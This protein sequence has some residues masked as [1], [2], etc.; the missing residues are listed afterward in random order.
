MMNRRKFIKSTSTIVAGAGILATSATACSGGG[1]L[2]IALIGA[3]NQGKVLLKDCLKISGIR[4]RAICDI[5]SFNQTYAKNTLKK[6]DQEVNVY[7]DYKEMLSTEKDLD[8]VIIATPDFVH[9]EHLFACLDAGLHVYCEKEMSHT[10]QEAARMVS[11][12]EKSNKL[13]Q[14]GHQRRS[15]P[16]YQMARESIHAGELCGQLTNCYGQWNRPVQEL[17]TWPEKYVIEPETLEKYGFDSMSHFR[18]WRWFKKYSGG[19]M[20]DLGSHQVDIFSWFINS[21]PSHLQATGGRD[22]YS[23]RDWDGDVMTIYNYYLNKENNKSVRAFYQV[24]NTNGFGSYYERFYGDSGSL[25]ISENGDQCYYVPE[26]GQPVPSWIE[27][28]EPVNMNGV[29]AY[30]L[31]AAFQNQSEESKERILPFIDKSI[32]QLHLEN[33]FNSII[34]NKKSNLNCSPSEAYRTAVAVLKAVEATEKEE[35]VRFSEND[36]DI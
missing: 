23:D 25:T 31:V 22:Y 29:L 21:D 35:T 26:F 20:A 14:I 8:A 18:N 15:N 36:F 4:F 1:E 7:T 9:A 32:H 33:F 11:A 27:Q 34:S 10:L 6:Y 16:V 3:G 30:P 13:V 28:T 24:L 19:P 5:W 17:Q 2:N 12:S